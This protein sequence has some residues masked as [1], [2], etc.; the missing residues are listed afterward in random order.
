MRVE[1]YKI[2]KGQLVLVDCGVPAQ[3]E[4]YAKQG[5]IVVKQG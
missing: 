2:V 5:Y 4:S 1:L 3:M